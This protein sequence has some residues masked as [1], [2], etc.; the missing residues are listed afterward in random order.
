MDAQG[1]T[2]RGQAVVGGSDDSGLF[3]FFD[4]NNWEMLVKVLDACP[5]NQ[6]HWVF[7]AATTDIQYTLRVTDLVTGDVNEYFNPLGNASAAIT[8]SNAFA[9]CDANPSALPPE[10]RLRV[11]RRIDLLDPPDGVAVRSFQ[12]DLLEEPGSLP[13]WSLPGGVTRTTSAATDGLQQVD[14]AQ[15][16]SGSDR[17]CLHRLALPRRGRLAQ[18]TGSDRSGAGGSFRFGRLGPVLVLRP[19]QLGDAGQ[20]AQ[21]LRAQQPLL[22]LLGCYHRCR[23]HLDGHGYPDRRHVAVLQSSGYRSGGDHRHGG[24]RHLQLIAGRRVACAVARR[25]LTTRRSS[26]GSRSA[27]RA[28]RDR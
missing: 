27:G 26:T 6:R 14:S 4:A 16:S 13:G 2:G 17:L 21:R 11:T 1:A 28:P 19:E 10:D 12:R 8:D 3:W 24:L 9:T 7:A 18:H 23:V 15:C 20:G 22:G 25:L 5:L